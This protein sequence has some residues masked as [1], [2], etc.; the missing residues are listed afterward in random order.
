MATE[1][2]MR[3]AGDVLRPVDAAGFEALAKVRSNTEVKVSV[4]VPRN[5]GYHRMFFAALNFAFQHQDT[6]PTLES[7]R[8]RVTVGAG[9]GTVVTRNGMMA[10]CPKSISFASMDDVAFHEFAERVVDE[11]CVKIVPGMDRQAVLDFF[12]ILDGSEPMAGM[13]PRAAKFTHPTQKK[14]AA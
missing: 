11:I 12:E 5:P 4:V 14:R 8:A 3:K 10:L 6:W 1:I 13:D 9:H 2:I 7:F